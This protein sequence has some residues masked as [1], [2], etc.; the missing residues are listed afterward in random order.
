VK[1][2]VLVP[3]KLYHPILPYK[4]NSKLMSPLCSACADTMNQD[5]C[6]H[7]EKGRCIVGTWVVDE[8]RKA[9]EMG[10]IVKEVFEFWEYKVTC[11]DKG[12][13]S[14]GLFTEYVNMFLKL[15]QESSGYP[16]WVQ[17]EEDRDR[18]IDEYRRA[19]GIPARRGNCFRQGINFQKRWAE[20]FG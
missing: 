18:Y 17:S 1:C 6:T 5:Y 11:F 14:G 12:S 10:Y 2:S 13:N 19:E 7:S 4:S 9:V 16:S 15:K 20:N 8:V 3:R